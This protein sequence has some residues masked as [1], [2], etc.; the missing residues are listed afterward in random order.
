MRKAK[1]RKLR[2][3]KV[4]RI[5]RTRARRH[6]KFSSIGRDL[7][8][9]ILNKDTYKTKRNITS[10]AV[11]CAATPNNKEFDAFDVDRWHQQRW[12]SGI[13]YHYVIKLDGTIQK[14]RWADFAGAHVKGNNRSTLAISYIGGLD[15]N[16]KAAEDQATAAQMLSLKNL[17]NLLK[18]MYNLDTSKILG[19]REYPRVHKACPCLNMDKVR[20]SLS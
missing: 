8:Q 11:H 16:R 9:E 5:T 14:G 4:N 20:S 1:L 10:I 3:R 15:A 12:G 2:R 17:L 13:G 7:T 18:D 19:H 6:K